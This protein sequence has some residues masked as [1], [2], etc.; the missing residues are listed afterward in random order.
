M[1]KQAEEN[2]E[3]GL[4]EEMALE[5]F[6]NLGNVCPFCGSYDITGASFETD[7]GSVYQEMS[8]SDCN[9]EWA[10]GYYLNTIFHDYVEDFSTFERDEVIK[11]EPLKI[12]VTV[13]SGVVQ[14]VWAPTGQQAIEV[15][16]LDLGTKDDEEEDAAARVEEIA[17]TMAAIY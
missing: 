1:E 8:C 13:S 7:A 15:E 3:Q 9:E 17:K 2:K 6:R 11:P 16:V 10:D 12:V 5:Y 14:S 4:T